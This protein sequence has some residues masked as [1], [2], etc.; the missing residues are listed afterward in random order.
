M[1]Y[2]MLPGWSSI[3]Y[4]LGYVITEW[5]PSGYCCAHYAADTTIAAYKSL[6]YGRLLCAYGPNHAYCT[7]WTGDG[8]PYDYRNWRIV[9]PQSGWVFDPQDP[10]LQERFQTYEI[11][12]PARVFDSQGQ[13]KCKCYVLDVDFETFEIAKD[14]DSM[15]YMSI[16]DEQLPVGYEFDIEWGGGIWPP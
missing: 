9:E 16:A 3:S 11:L 12:F 4:H 1:G 15:G 7:Y 5:F 14:T 8:D 6:G 13:P 10:D 2:E